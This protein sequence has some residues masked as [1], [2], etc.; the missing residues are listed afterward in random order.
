VICWGAYQVVSN[1]SIG[2]HSDF[3][4]LYAWSRHL[5]AG[6][7]KHPPLGAFIVRAWFMVFPASDWAFRLLSVVYSALGLF[8]VYLIARHALAP[9]R[10]LPAVLLLLLTP[11]YQFLTDRFGANQTLLLAWPL[12]TFCF[13]RAFETRAI[14]WSIAAGAA[15]AL[16]MLGKYYSAYLIASFVLAAIVHPARLAYLKS[17]SPWISTA[18][19]LLVLAPH[20]HWLFASNFES[21]GYAFAVHSTSRSIAPW[22]ALVY[23][24]SACGYVGVLVAAWWLAVRPSRLLLR[25]ILWPTDPGRRM[26]VV[27]LAGQI[28]LP[29]LSAILMG[30]ALTAL[31]TM[32]AWFLL[33]IVLLSAPQAGMPPRAA[34][35]LALG[36]AGFTL[37]A[38]VLA[39]AIAWFQLAHGTKEGDEYFPGMAKA[40][41]REWR[42]ATPAPLR[43]VVATSELAN[44]AVFYVPTHPDAVPDFNLRNSPWL[45]SADYARR[46][47]AVI[48]ASA[49]SSCQQTAAAII[50]AAHNARRAEVEIIPHYLGA[51]ARPARFTFWIAPP[52]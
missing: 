27:L 47:V 48:C 8:A 46:G 6:Y 40:L 4:E 7:S 52:Q 50:R 31:W 44:A 49:D 22:D 45:T 36:V 41:Q 21:V 43:L 26:L 20:I 3:C 42:A 23:V 39:P 5:S 28:L 35:R 37:A 38:I 17:S 11:F 14:A 51:S 32:E 33:P 9:G 30:V 12:A 1:G 16:A 34:N 10:R 18:T 19:G 2:L 13:L 15:A 29:P 24:V 25:E